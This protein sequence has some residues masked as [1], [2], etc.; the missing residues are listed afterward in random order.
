MNQIF[1]NNFTDI[2]YT[3]FLY[4]SIY[5]I[6]DMFTAKARPKVEVAKLL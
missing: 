1:F 2:L 5:C 6:E 3:K 4:A